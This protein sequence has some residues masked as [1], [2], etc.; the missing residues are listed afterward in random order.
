MI[1]NIKEDDDIAIQFDEA[2]DITG[3]AQLIAFSKFVFNGD[4]TEISLICRP[5]PETA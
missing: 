4:I 5:L 1:A 2:T 3:K